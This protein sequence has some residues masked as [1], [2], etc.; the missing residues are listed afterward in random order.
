MTRTDTDKE[1]Q[2]RKVYGIRIKWKSSSP[3]KDMDAS[4]QRLNFCH[5]SSACEWNFSFGRLGN[6]MDCCKS[7]QPNTYVN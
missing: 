1:Y 7:T 5:M 3:C 2:H 6:A 4:V